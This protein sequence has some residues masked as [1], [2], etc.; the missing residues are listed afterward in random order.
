MESPKTGLDCS[1]MIARAAQICGIPY[2]YKNTTIIERFLTPLAKGNKPIPGDII[3][4][5]GHVMVVA[6]F[7]N[8]TLIEV[9]GY[10]HGYSKIHEIPLNEEFKG[11]NTYHDLT[12]AYH[13]NKAII[14]LDSSG[15]ER[16]TITSLKLLQLTSKK[17][18]RVFL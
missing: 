7:I 6:D 18:K 12:N 15:N 10:K 2:F 8:N 13:N 3:W 1:G 16:E 14:R 9:R 11:I 4:I 17:S 5:P